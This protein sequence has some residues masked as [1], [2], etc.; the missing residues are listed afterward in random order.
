MAETLDIECDI[1]TVHSLSVPGYK[2]MY[3]ALIT[4]VPDV[5]PL[6]VPP[7]TEATADVPLL[8]VA[9]DVTS[10]LDDLT[11]SAYVIYVAVAVVVSP[12]L[13]AESASFTSSA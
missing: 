5:F 2:N 8:H 7:D 4:D 12:T 1:G 11:P 6:T 3:V 10:L 9:D 13:M